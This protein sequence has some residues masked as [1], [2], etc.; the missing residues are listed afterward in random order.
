M[1]ASR[2]PER[3]DRRTFLGASTLTLTA[4]AFAAAHPRSAWGQAPAALT[5]DGARPGVPY[6]VQSG[7][8]SG[9]RAVVWSATDRPARF[10]VEW[11]TSDA[12]KNS[13]R[14]M[15]PAALPESDFTA[16]V[17]LTGL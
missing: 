16:R 6:G 12:F 14:V 4:L 5:R 9:D 17:D 3:L 1:T 2:R 8:V 10:I 15:G 7:D 11:A 13:R